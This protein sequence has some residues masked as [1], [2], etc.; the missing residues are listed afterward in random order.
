LS[1]LFNQAAHGGAGKIGPEQIT[2][3]PDPD[4]PYKMTDEYRAILAGSQEELNLTKAIN[5]IESGN[6]QSYEPL[7]YSDVQ[8]P[9]VSGWN[10]FYDMFYLTDEI[11]LGRIAHIPGTDTYYY[12]PYHY[13][14]GPGAPNVWFQFNVVDSCKVTGKC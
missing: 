13:N 5:E 6:R 7:R 8:L 4:N 3:V 10:T 14:V 11:A 2:Y 9:K 12:S 1:Y